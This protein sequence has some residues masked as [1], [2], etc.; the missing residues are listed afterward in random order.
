VSPGSIPCEHGTETTPSLVAAK[1]SDAAVSLMVVVP[2]SDS[3]ASGDARDFAF[4]RE[5]AWSDRLAIP[6]AIPLRV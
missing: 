1:N 3:V 5:S 4:G 6:L 2:V